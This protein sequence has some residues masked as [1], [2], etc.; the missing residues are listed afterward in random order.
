ML[1]VA[2]FGLGIISYLGMR[3]ELNPDVSFGTIT[4]STSYPG[5]AP[6]DINDLVSRKIEQAVSGVTGVRE[7][8]S[9]S[10][11][12]LSTVAVT[13]ELDANTDSALNDVRS[14][15]D[16]VTNSLPKDALKPQ[17]IKFDNSSAPVL[18]LSFS[19]TT[20]ASRELRDLIDNTLSDRFAQIAGVASATVQGGDT[21]EIQVQVSRDK[22]RAY[23]I[24]IADV[25][26]GV[27]GAS[28]NA[29]SGHLVNGQQDYTVRVKGDFTTLDDVKD[30]VINVSDPTNLL[31]K[32][33]QV[34]LTDIAAVKDTV[35]ERTAYSRL[36]GND[37]IVLAIQKLREGNSV[38][39]ATAAKKLI[40][41]IEKEYKAQ[42]VHIVA[43][44]DQSKQIIDSVSDLRFALVFGIFLVAVIVFV[45]LHNM[46]G[47]LIVALAIPTS[48]FASFIAMKLAGFTINNMS[49]LALSLAIGV[50]VDDAIVVLEN[51][52]RHLK[53]GEDPREA[54]LN[55]RMEIGLAALAITLADV[56][57]FLPIAFMGGIV[58]QFF[59]PLALGFVFATLFS[60]F[61]SFTLTPLLAA[62]WYKA[63]ED[64]E[65]ATGGFA[66]WFEGRFAALELKYRHALEWALHHRWFV[67]CFG[68]AA[69]F[70][71][72]A[73]I[74]GSFSP[75]QVPQGLPPGAPIPDVGVI[76]ALK[77]AV[78]MVFFKGA[79]FFGIV[80]MIGH[81]LKYKRLKAK[82]VLAG[83]A[84]GLA[85]PISSL[86]GYEYAQWKGES[87][88]KF[89]FLPDSDGGQVTANIELP[90]GSSLPMTEAVV[91]RVE[92]VFK[93]DPDVQY[94]VSNV[95]TQG[96]GN[97][98]SSNNGPNYAQVQAT[99][100]DKQAMTDKLPWN[101]HEERLR[102]RS[103]D[104]VSA[105]LTE[106]VGRVPGASV[107]IAAQSGFGF[108]A[109][110]QLS[111]RSDNRDLL[112]QTAEK[113]KDGLASGVIKGIINP[114]ISSKPG[115]PELRVTPNR[116]ALADSGI[117]VPTLGNAVRNLY[118][119][120]N[121][122]KLRVNGLEYDVR[123]MMDYADRDNPANLATVPL[124]YVQGQPILLGSVA[125][126]TVAPG[127]S[128]I[129]RRDRS[130]EVQV[131]ADILPGYANGSVNADVVKWL[132][133][134][135]LVPEGVEFKPLGAADAQSREIGF[136]M[137]AL[138]M[139]VVLVYMLLAS[140]YDNLLYPFIIQ[141]AQPQAMVG[142]LLALMIMNQSLNLVGFI[143]IIALIG[144]VA[145]NAILVVDYT[146]TL[147]DRGR[148]RHDALVEAGPTRLRPIMMT[149]LA[150]ILGMLPVAM[151]LGR[152]SEFRQTIG[153]IVIGGITL[154]TML[155]LL[156]IPCSYTIFDDLSNA[157]SKMLGK[158][159]AHGGALDD[160]T[161]SEPALTPTSTK[162]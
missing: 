125:N 96:V 66:I 52:Y 50:L 89:S 47:T 7:V 60:L 37:S 127:V 41:D 152:G 29:P 140:L 117:D 98:S 129:T 48:I 76:G 119:G 59:K 92:K 144:L 154:S 20:L 148:N 155:T 94:V 115:R 51:I 80:T 134:K 153:T 99:L 68:N 145:K 39:I 123:V 4:I 101:H 61:V 25:L 46:R 162:S 150:L 81:F 138:F 65:H 126:V 53:M 100:Y 118:Q 33:R 73:F 72:I 114:D 130:E 139:G 40:T 23:G 27:T 149:T 3:V 74:G 75:S 43:T 128:L 124:K 116:M 103:A 104:S 56:V 31:G 106:K 17:V 69:L 82:F 26:S 151:A 44:F 71:V 90:T 14:K 158:A 142:A 161:E 16:A 8:T 97:G 55:G 157:F 13:L 19:S 70:A 32:P 78:G 85:F 109:A 121:D 111:F 18:N 84:F 83:L 95:G 57:V 86:I 9:S 67:F 30:S 63:G 12:G 143:G 133:D 91:E 132:T 105:S 45:F 34:R 49:M 10:Q 156:V 2:A 147:R 136:L 110:V 141:L 11:E 77:G 54:A 5:A 102:A 120:N 42:G 160:S 87:V 58:G 21:R 112:M 36:N 113:V 62:R 88:F 28:L 6:E 1:M 64:M 35:V 131:T 108:G 79:I 93:D 107:K 24:G 135:H 146:N 38:Q 22:L 159:P 122:N 137:G 15:V